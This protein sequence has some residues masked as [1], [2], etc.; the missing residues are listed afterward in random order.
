MLHALTL[1]PLVAPAAPAPAPSDALLS[2]VPADALVCIHA[3][4]PKALIASRDTN[5]WM[6]FAL[7]A[8][9]E[10]VIDDLTPLTTGPKRSPR[11]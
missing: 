9:W 5:A 7:D 6:A 2:V 8:R 4:N 1:L 11:R 3:P 10:S